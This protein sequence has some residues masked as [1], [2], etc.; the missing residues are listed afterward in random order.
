MI[1][2][3]AAVIVVAAVVVVG[4]TAAIVSAHM[5]AEAA[6]EVA[7]TN[8]RATVQAAKEAA[9][10]HIEA[11]KK[12]AGARMHESD[13]AFN[14]EMEYLKHEKYMMEQE[15]SQE[16]YYKQTQMEVDAIDMYYAESGPW[17]ESTGDAGYDYGYDA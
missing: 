10:A 1:G 13:V 17:G 12:Y 6:K 7:E 14:Q 9:N 4:A 16:N 5:S 2:T 8:A 15:S 3:V 11:A